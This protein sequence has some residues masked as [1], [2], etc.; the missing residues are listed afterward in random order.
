MIEFPRLLETMT[1]R[2]APGHSFDLPFGAPSPGRVTAKAEILN[3]PQGGMS[4]LA[5]V[6]HVEILN[7]RGEHVAAG[8]GVA[9]HV[10]PRRIEVALPGAVWKCQVTNATT[11]F[12][13]IRCTVEFTSRQR[14]LSKRVDLDFINSKLHE[15]WNDSQPLVISFKNGKVLRN[16]GNR[17]FE[18]QLE[19]RGIDIEKFKVEPGIEDALRDA[20]I[21]QVALIEMARRAAVSERDIRIGFFNTVT[22]T[23]LEF[24]DEDW[25]RQVGN[26][27]FSLGKKVFSKPTSSTRI[28]LRATIFDGKLA[29]RIQII[30][31]NNTG[32]IQIPSHPDLGIESFA[33]TIHLV[34]EEL[35]P[36]RF[37]PV[38]RVSLE[39][40]SSFTGDKLELEKVARGTMVSEIENKVFEEQERAESRLRELAEGL[41]TWSLGARR[42]AHRFDSTLDIVY[43]QKPLSTL[44][45]VDPIEHSMGPLEVGNLAKIDH[46]IVLMMEN[47][48]FDHMLGYL[49]HTETRDRMSDVRGLS[50]IHS[51]HFQG[52]TKRS[53]LLE[54]TRIE[55]DPCHDFDCTE[56]QTSGQMEGFVESYWNK[57]RKRFK[58]S[59]AEALARMGDVMGYYNA[60]HLWVYDT[61]A[62]SYAI[63]DQWFAAHPGPTW[64]NR[65]MTLSGKLAPG[66]DGKPQMD[67]PDFLTFAPILERNLFDHLTRGGVTWR[68]YEHDV[69]MIRT[70]ERYTFDQENVV[71]VDDPERGFYAAAREG[72]LPQVVFIDPNLTEIP[73]GNDDHPPSDV[74]DGQ[75]LVARIY[76]ALR[77]SPAWDRL[78]FIIVYDEHGGFFDH[79]KPRSAAA[80]SGVGRT[81]VRV[82][83]LVISGLVE[84]ATID[85]TVYDHTTIIKTILTRFLPARPPWVGERV[86]EAK[87]L[88]TLLTRSTARP[89]IEVPE[90]SPVMAAM[91]ARVVRLYFPPLPED[92][93]DFHIFMRRFSQ[94]IISVNQVTL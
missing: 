21:F 37:Q 30:F 22:F 65:F 88:G 63:C 58:L 49:S 23:F 82:P 73:P 10:V 29:L 69:G 93:R 54:D 12:R 8:G 87:D 45:A 67:N 19:A 5:E 77:N 83:A 70:F 76:N 89:G 92:P 47:R 11:S 31:P 60:S 9:E 86:A 13:T 26:R 25:Q 35:R 28:F 52:Q 17:E 48:S 71:S 64:P 27:A 50:E 33:I 2:L 24:Q 15:L 56:Q 85:H 62:R 44:G 75:R 40:E 46:I 74:T 38:V 6:A 14:L 41:V 59:E 7:S 90:H 51:N 34:V 72:N 68:Y 61:L 53:F 81:G 1:R 32:E 3:A 4:S 91:P 20:G 84:P 16:T 94:R 66:L 80:V 39:L 18:S 55:Y 79:I 42:E 36:P 43:L 78:L 57:L